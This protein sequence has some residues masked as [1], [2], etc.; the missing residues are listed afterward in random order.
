MAVH[1]IEVRAW[2]AHFS[3]PQRSTIQRSGCIQSAS[4]LALAGKGTAP[5]L[6]TTARFPATGNSGIIATW[7]TRGSVHGAQRTGPGIRR[8]SG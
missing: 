7:A 8:A 6:S 4:L 1:R 2:L 3:C 5:H